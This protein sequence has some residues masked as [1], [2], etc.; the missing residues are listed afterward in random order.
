VELYLS[1]RMLFIPLCLIKHKDNFAPSSTPPLP[2]VEVSRTWD[3]AQY[4]MSQHRGP[5]DVHNRCV[6]NGSYI[7]ENF[8]FLPVPLSVVYEW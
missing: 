2:N 5:L 7:K 3:A 6:H 4:S 1:S 8:S